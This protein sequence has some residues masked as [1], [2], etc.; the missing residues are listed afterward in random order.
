MMLLHKKITIK[1]PAQQVFAYWADFRNFQQFI[2][3]IETIDILDD[4][5]SRWVIHAPLG[6]KVVFESLI[7]TFE[8]G[9][10]LVWE[11]SHA[12]GFARGQLRLFGQGENTQVELDFEYSLHRHWM[13]N[14]ARLVSHFGF[15]S[16]AFDHGLARIKEQ[17]EKDNL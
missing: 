9:K 12:D 16:L 10:N 5:R 4:K 6:H 17:I 1:A 7:T 11:S 15:P 14:V 13:Q 8:P 3:L 2:P